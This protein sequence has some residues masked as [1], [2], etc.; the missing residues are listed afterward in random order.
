[1]CGM[2][3]STLWRGARPPEH[4]GTGWVPDGGVTDGQCTPSA[5]WAGAMC[6]RVGGGPSRTLLGPRGADVTTVMSD[7]E[8]G[9]AECVTCRCRGDW[10]ND[11]A[12]E[13]WV[14]G[15]EP[16]IIRLRGTLDR[17]TL[18]DLVSAVEELLAEGGRRLD[19]QGHSLRL[20]DDLEDDILAEL[21]GLVA[22]SGGQVRWSAHG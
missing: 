6:P 10:R 3:L 7:A 22:G 18:S 21:E 9:A 12:L 1:M 2:G 17:A 4:G 16:V 19:L 8:R 14:D 20:A 15:Q 5:K 13:M 11:V